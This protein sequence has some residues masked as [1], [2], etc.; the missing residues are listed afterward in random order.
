MQGYKKKS[1]RAPSSPL[2][3]TGHAVAAVILAI[4]MVV[5]TMASR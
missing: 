1:R 2:T 5:L 3:P 4:V